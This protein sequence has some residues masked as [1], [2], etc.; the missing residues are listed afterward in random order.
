VT[1]LCSTLENDTQNVQSGLI[2]QFLQNR[3]SGWRWITT[4]APGHAFYVAI[5]KQQ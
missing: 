1:E 3:F 2:I 4:H 5:E